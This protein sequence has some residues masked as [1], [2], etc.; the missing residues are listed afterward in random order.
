M[1][2]RLD[3]GV[4]AFLPDNYVIEH[5]DYSGDNK[6]NLPFTS[7]KIL[8]DDARSTNVTLIMPLGARLIITTPVQ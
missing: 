7:A 1:S 4:S 3:I 5:S 2:G 6:G 8:S